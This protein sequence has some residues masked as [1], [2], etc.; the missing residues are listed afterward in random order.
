MC[1]AYAL[2]RLLGTCSSIELW[3]GA[4]RLSRNKTGAWL[5]PGPLYSVQGC[6]AMCRPHSHVVGVWSPLSQ[7]EFAG[8]LFPLVG[9]LRGDLTLQG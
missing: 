4:R 6:T 9:P 5:G 3:N 2:T 8:L 7:G 1:Q